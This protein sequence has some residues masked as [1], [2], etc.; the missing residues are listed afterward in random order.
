MRII[1]EIKGLYPT[2]DKVEFC[3]YMNLVV[4]GMIKAFGHNE[5]RIMEIQYVKRKVSILVR[6]GLGKET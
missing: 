4:K 3:G 6:E 1:R 2:T 5:W